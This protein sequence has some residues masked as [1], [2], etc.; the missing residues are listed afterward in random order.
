MSNAVATTA[1]DC[2][3]TILDNKLAALDLHLS[4]PTEV[5]IGVG[6]DPRAVL[7]WAEFLKATV[8]D[9]ERRN[10]DSLLTVSATLQGVTWTV[11][12]SF[13]KQEDAGPRS[14]FP[15]ITVQWKTRPI[16]GARSSKGTITVAQLEVLIGALGV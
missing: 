11:T 1:L 10:Q 8:V 6:V 16:G 12:G 3:Q 4:T 9:V 7:K 2:A 14:R 13:L 5:S 15:G